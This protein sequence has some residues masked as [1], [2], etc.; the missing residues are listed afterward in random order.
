M[1]FR[2]PDRQTPQHLPIVLALASQSG[3]EASAATEVAAHRPDYNGP[4]PSLP[5]LAQCRG[6]HVSA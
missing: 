1:R 3:A 4:S 5:T 2:H 6:G